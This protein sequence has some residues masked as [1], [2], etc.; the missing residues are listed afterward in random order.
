MPLYIIEQQPS[1]GQQITRGFAVSIATAL[2]Q[3]AEDKRQEIAQRKAQQ[4]YEQQIATQVAAQQRLMELAHQQK[5]QEM[6]YQQQL[7]D[8]KKV[9][10]IMRK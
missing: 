5:L 10:P 2:E 8:Q 6:V 1:F 4:A 3:L 7:N 9:V